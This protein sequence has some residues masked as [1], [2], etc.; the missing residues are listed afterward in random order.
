[1]SGRPFKKK[2]IGTLAFASLSMLTEGMSDNC[3][4][5]QKSLGPLHAIFIVNDFDS[6]KQLHLQT[7]YFI[8]PVSILHVSD[9]GRGI[10]EGIHAATSSK[11]YCFVYT[12]AFGFVCNN[13]VHRFLQL[14]SLWSSLWFQT[15]RFRQH[16]PEILKRLDL[17][18]GNKTTIK[19]VLFA[20]NGTA[21]ERCCIGYVVFNEQGSAVFSTAVLPENTHSPCCHYSVLLAI[22]DGDRPTVKSGCALLGN[23]NVSC[24]PSVSRSIVVQ[25]ALLPQAICMQGQANMRTDS[26][27]QAA[28]AV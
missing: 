3:G 22:N 1:M 26:Q 21:I 20:L 8:Q 17:Q 4:I 16:L 5:I 13:S 9:L 19:I 11:H 14:T 12:L 24:R 7:D 6:N 2:Y 28:L 27:Y 25:P 15:E 10:T 18:N 23:S